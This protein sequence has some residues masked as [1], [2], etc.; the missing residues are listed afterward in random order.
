MKVFIIAALVVAAIGSQ[1]YFENN[2]PLKEQKHYSYQVPY[3][4]PNYNNFY[5]DEYDFRHNY[6]HPFIETKPVLAPQKTW[7][8]FLIFFVKL[9]KI[10][11]V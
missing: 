11:H 2:Y 1:S 10:L 5:D 7:P 6:V 8:R 4:L 9:R 3:F